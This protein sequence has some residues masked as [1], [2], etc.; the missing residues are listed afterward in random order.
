MQRFS[1][2]QV[3]RCSLALVAA[4]SV[5]LVSGHG[6]ITWPPARN[7]GS[8]AKAGYSPQFEAFWFS[9]ISVIP[10]SPTLP[11]YAR[12]MNINVDGGEND[13]T[14]QMPW[15]APGTAPVYGSGCGVAG[16]SPFSNMTHNGGFAPPGYEYGQ[17]F[18][19]IPKTAVPYTLARGSVQEM[20][21]AALANHG[22]GYSWRLCKNL[23]GEVSEACFQKNVLKFAPDDAGDNSSLVR[24]GKRFQWGAQPD[25]P[26]FKIPRVTT[27]EGTFPE[28]SEWA[29]V[30]FPPCNLCTPEVHAAC[31]QEPKWLDQQYCT[32][33]CSGVNMTHCPPGMT[34]FPEPL[35]GL[36]GFSQAPGA[37][38]NGVIGFTYNIV[39]LLIIPSDIEAG[40]YLLSWRW[41][42]EQ[43]K[44]IWQ[45]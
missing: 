3:V 36:S 13:F 26:D 33:T 32:Q 5:A 22:G 43:S 10:G 29:R 37:C 4:T 44:Q 19:T 21:W 34:Q 17:D 8:L 30:P 41:D 14:A 40:D 28:G 45:V 11:S 20:A 2:R 1:H 16:G 9:Q 6:S 27:T 12:T 35:P 7:N 38:N 39:D 23:P 18:L 31:H 24:Y 15:R 42:C 25:L